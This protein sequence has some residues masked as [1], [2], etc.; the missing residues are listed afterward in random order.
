VLQ[1]GPPAVDT[2]DMTDRRPNFD[3][4]LESARSGSPWAFGWLYRRFQPGLLR[5]LAVIAPHQAEDIAADVWL[6]VAAT[7]PRFDGG[8]R[9]FR[10]WLA[11]TARYQV[12]EATRRHGRR[13]GRVL[14][15]EATES[16]ASTSFAAR[17]VAVLPPEQ[18]DV[19]LLRVVK[20][21]DV[22]EVAKV[23]GRPPA[24]VRLLQHRA[25]RRLAREAEPGVLP[26]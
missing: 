7:I 22:E 13:V 25:L 20:G 11:S 1:E 24:A 5:M 4:V 26:V 17:V 14:D 21:L 9:A 10:A 23:V 18:A 15:D 12:I 8:E 6:E 19:V 3:E 16:M 2:L